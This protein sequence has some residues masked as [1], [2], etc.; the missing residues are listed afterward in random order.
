[1]KKIFGIIV[2]LLLSI[3]I[4]ISVNSLREGD[5]T[6]VSEYSWHIGGLYGEDL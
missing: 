1:M 5:T 3:L 2:L 6:L 4:G